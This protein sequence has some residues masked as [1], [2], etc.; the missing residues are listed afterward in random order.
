MASFS[1]YTVK[2][3]KELL[4]EFSTSAEVGLTD[5]AVSSLQNKH[6]KNEIR[7]KDTT[8]I[9]LLLRQIR[10]PFIY[11]LFFAAVLAIALGEA[12]DGILI[13]LFIFINTA[14]GFY[15]EYH[16]AHALALL[17][18]FMV[19]RAR[20]I[21]N[22]VETVVNSNEIV[23]GD[24]IIL[25]TGDIIPADVRVIES[26]SLT[27]DESILTGE[28]VPV[29][30]NS[31]DLGSSTDQVYK[32][33]NI[34]FTGTTI[35]SGKG[36]AVVLFIG[37]ETNLGDITKL[38]TQ[39][40]HQSS[41][42]KSISK[43][44]KFIL[45]LVLV[46]LAFVFIANIFIK[47]SSVNLTELIIFSI[48]LAV[49]VIPEGLPVVMTFS[50]ARGAIS[51]AKNHV[52]VK[53]LSAIE[54]LGS[55]EILCTDKTG[56]LTQNKLTVSDIKTLASENVLH[57]ASLAAPFLDETSARPNNAFDIAIH[58]ALSEDEKKSLHEYIRVSEIPFD[59]KR[60]RNTMLLKKENHFSIVVRGAYEDIVKESSNVSVETATEIASWVSEMGQQGKRVI[61]VAYKE[62]GLEAA[63]DLLAVEND[64]KLLGLVSFVD[65]IK[66]STI[67]A[68]KKARA[69]GVSLKIITGD[70]REV[71]G[72]VAY[73]IGLTTSFHEV[74]TGEELMSLS[75]ED[76]KKKVDEYSVFARIT[77]EQKYL[78]VQL[79]QEK[80]EIGFLGEG[81]ND[82]PALKI[83]NVGLVVE[84]ASDV[85]REAADI[86]LLEKS[87]DVIV[88]GI[89]QGRSV[90]ANTLKY[91][92]A[93]L[94]S[95]FGNFYAVAVASLI[96]DYLPMLSIQLLLCNLLSD[97]PMISI[98]TDTVDDEDVAKPKSYDVRDIALF[99]TV[100]GIT[101]TVF[102]FIIFGLFMHNE[103]RVLQTNWFVASVLT[104]LLFLF[105][106][107]SKLFF[108]HAKRP[109]SMVLFLT[110]CAAFVT[111]LMPFTPFGQSVFKFV[112][113]TW[114][115]LTLIAIVLTTY[116]IVTESV[117]HYYYSFRQK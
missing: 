50:L 29:E 13:I 109:S 95:N 84:G 89:K 38:A 37:T 114:E 60:R 92:K 49:S 67:D 40:K 42:D 11:M 26:N 97:F 71:A 9:E 32:A 76:Q 18:K 6:G 41:F 86:V 25:E 72:A 33:L 98:A 2:P 64:L 61:A 110:G 30:K 55:I 63:T 39:T 36:K 15:Q 87:L 52:V 44:S 66:P 117:K 69:L 16:S 59:P 8:V 113:P 96:I 108:L 77:P 34:G 82:A 27:I 94:A 51:L 65:P 56:T 19:R 3:L 14:L 101:S 45:N 100:L 48:A 23:P 79:L 81:I 104:E 102:D 17:K 53:R 75:H 90:F 106:I 91:V 10:S 1:S 4:S 54:D 62:L 68:I 93:T 43:L 12:A 24:I 46:T 35:V 21:R 47:G 103:P 78:I 105:S 31:N 112:P 57:Y 58:S 116:L 80:Y 28:S 88:D 111:V 20:L 85:A 7:S 107:R 22:G 83:A 115:H 73:Q 70:S 99:A 5:N 74:I